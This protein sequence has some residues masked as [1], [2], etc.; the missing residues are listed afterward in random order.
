MHS[1]KLE[2]DGRV[3]SKRIDDLKAKNMKWQPLEESHPEQEPFSD[4]KMTTCPSSASRLDDVRLQV[5]A[6]WS[7]RASQGG[8]SV[9]AA[10]A[11]S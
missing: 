2:E 3:I 9:A 6:C 1:G 10:F 8:T 7:V 11:T 4:Q 5:A